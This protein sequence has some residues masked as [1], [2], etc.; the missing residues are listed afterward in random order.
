MMT[1]SQINELE[2]AFLQTSTVL[3]NVINVL[4]DCAG[5]AEVHHFVDIR[6]FVLKNLT[7]ILDTEGGSN[8]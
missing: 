2:I 5:D 4:S 3:Q 7:R 8:G 1:K 6:F